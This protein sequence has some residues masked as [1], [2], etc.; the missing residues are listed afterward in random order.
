[1]TKIALITGAT[2]GIGEATAILLAEN[3]YDLI[4]TGRRK[5]RLEILSKKLESEK[6][7]KTICLDF[8]IRDKSEVEKAFRKLSA[9]WLCIDVLIN[10]AGLAAGLDTIQEGSLEDWEQM[11]DT[12]VKGLLYISKLVM[13]L[14]IKQKQGHIIN[15]GSVAGKETY[16]KGNVYCATKHAVEAITKGMRIDLNPYGIKV[17][18]IC[19][20]MVETEF[21]VVRLK[22]PNANRQVYKG[23]IPLQA[24]DIAETILF[25]ITRPAHVNV[26][27]VLIFP[28]SQASATVVHK[29]L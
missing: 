26:A 12:N 18:A 19:P 25:M 15:I 22:D 20:G 1:M 24:V 5:E 29:E 8:D 10:N 2:S 17:G 28:T 3:G 16:P 6:Q 7:R 11:I 27:D 4:L 14:M 21:S 9:E 23:L 13:P